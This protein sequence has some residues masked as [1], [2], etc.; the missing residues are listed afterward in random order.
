MWMKMLDKYIL[1]V[2]PQSL[3]GSPRLTLIITSEHN[4]CTSA[5]TNG[6]LIEIHL[7]FDTVLLFSSDTMSVTIQDSTFPRT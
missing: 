7:L 6:M 2:L 3:W 1:R 4:C 5:N